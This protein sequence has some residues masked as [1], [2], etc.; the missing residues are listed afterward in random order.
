ML[1]ILFLLVPGGPLQLVAFFMC[2][3]LEIAIPIFVEHRRQLPFLLGIWWIAIRDNADR[4]VNIVLPVGAVLVLLDPVLPIP[5][6]LTAV[7]MVIV[8][9][10]LVVRPP[11]TRAEPLIA[12]A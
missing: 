2:A 11:V 6:T 5:V 9:A 10:V 7:V 12:E 3:L 8:V 4:V 1:W